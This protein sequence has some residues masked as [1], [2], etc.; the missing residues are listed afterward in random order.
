VSQTTTLLTDISATDQTISLA[1]GTLAG[2]LIIA[3]DSEYCLV[4][5]KLNATQAI[6]QRGTNASVAASHLAGT[7]VTIGET[8]EFQT[9]NQFLPPFG[10]STTVLTANGPESPATF[11][12]GGGGGGGAPSNA[13]YVTL[14][15]NAG[16]T[17][18]R[19][20][21][22]GTGITV[23]DGGANSTVT[24]AA[25]GAPSAAQYVTLATD[26]TLPN[27]RVLTAGTGITLT[28]G[29]AGST[30]TIAATGGGTG[31]VVGPASATDGVPALFN[32]T[33]GKLIKNSTPTGTGNPVMQTSPSLTTPNLGTPSAVNLS[34]GT[35]LPVAGIG[36]LG[37]NVGTF[38]ITPS[39]ANLRGAL[40]DETGTGV[41]V[42]NDTPT[43]VAP[44]LGTPTS[45]TLTNCT[46]L[47]IAGLTPSTSTAIGVGSIELGDASNTSIT[48]VSAGIIA[49]EGDTVATLARAETF[50]NT[51]TFQQIVFTNNAITATSNAATVPIT[52]RLNTVT[53]NSAATLT[54][55]LTTTSAVDGQASIIRVLDS[56]GVAQTL[57]WVNTENST[58]SVP[59]TS[60]GSTTL[61]L[62]VGFMYN[63][64][65]T[66]WRCVASA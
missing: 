53:N 12:P 19:V 63:S 54:I 34:N 22:A 5:K 28:D 8:S 26:A 18:E 33:T 30:I 27:E 41:A 37:T 64:A 3:L 46:G 57:S 45:G 35:A 31:D 44:V 21:T 36:N 47:P 49:V 16:L 6:I 51:Q 38:L 52:S 55:T 59:A 15:L 9:G 10:E 65:T 56:S 61:P 62:T 60:N 40:T 29:G 48:R 17:Q 7:A 39:S 32:G 25:T 23:T 1:S 50:T 2:G 20:L 24:I 66:K 11:Q 58:V 42:F 14:A 13:Q 43:L 4:I